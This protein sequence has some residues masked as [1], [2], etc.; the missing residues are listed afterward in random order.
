MPPLEL[1]EP[2]E[3]VRLEPDELPPEKLELPDDPL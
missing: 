2:L 3:P 1:D